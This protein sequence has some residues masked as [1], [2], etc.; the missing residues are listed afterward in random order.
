MVEG[1]YW[2]LLLVI[3]SGHH[4]AKR[5]SGALLS[6]FRVQ[7]QIISIVVMSEEWGPPIA[8]R[9]TGLW[10]DWLWI[11]A[12][13]DILA[14]WSAC[15]DKAFNTFLNK[16]LM[17]HLCSSWGWVWM[18]VHRR[19]FSKKRGQKF[20]NLPTDGPG[21]ILKFSR[22]LPARHHI[23]SIHLQNMMTARS[24]QLFKAFNSGILR[25]KYITCSF[26]AVKTTIYLNEWNVWIH[27]FF[28]IIYPPDWILEWPEISYYSPKVPLLYKA[29]KGISRKAT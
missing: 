17:L 11:I 4:W 23:V 10:V 1:V 27:C 7:Q 16:V 26:Y 29:W 9:T 22:C 13:K 20:S 15:D 18:F 14:A 21:R 3:T 25:W 5:Q 8:Y 19:K 12:L 28:D 2:N 6:S 24:N